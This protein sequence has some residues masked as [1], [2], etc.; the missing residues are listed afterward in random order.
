METMR[1]NRPGV[2][3]RDGITLTREWRC[4]RE[5]GSKYGPCT[6]V[7]LKRWIREGSKWAI[8]HIDFCGWQWYVME[9]E[10]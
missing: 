5:D 3:G 1:V 4:W 6:D 7:V 10:M 8:Y 9:R 2:D